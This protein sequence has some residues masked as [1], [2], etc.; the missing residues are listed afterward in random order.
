VFYQNSDFSFLGQVFQYYLLGLKSGS[1]EDRINCGITGHTMDKCYKLHGYPPGYRSKGKGPVAN[2]VSL[3][4]FGT[5]ATAMIDEMSPFQIT[6]IQTQ[7]QQLFATLNTKALPSP[8]SEPS[9]SNAP[10]QAMANTTFSP[11]SLPSHSVSGNPLYH[12]ICSPIGFTPNFSHSVFSSNVK[13]PMVVNENLWVIDTGATNHMVHSLSC[14]TTITSTVNASVELP[15]GDL[16]SVTHI[17]N[18]KFSPSLILTNVLCVPSFHLNLISISKLVHSLSFCLIFMTNYCLIQAFTPW[19][20]I[21]LG[22]LHN[23]LYLLQTQVNQSSYTNLLHQHSVSHVS[24]FIN[25]TFVSASVQLTSM[26][27]WHYRLGHP[28][29]D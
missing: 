26:Q 18:V 21:G 9:S 16:V 20:M 6:Q 1:V 17:G 14:L 4:N 3:N 11:S 28:S 23:G 15:N 7:C 22:K 27:L 8:T 5:N 2:Q 13:L 29:F 25:N 19:R 24:P 12:S 10:Y